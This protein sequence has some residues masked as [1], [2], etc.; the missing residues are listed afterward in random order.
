M[1]ETLSKSYF[2][3]HEHQCDASDYFTSG[4]NCIN[5]DDDNEDEKLNILISYEDLSVY[6]EEREITLN[7]KKQNSALKNVY[8]QL[9]DIL[10]KKLFILAAVD[11][12]SAKISGCYTIE[13]KNK[14]EFFEGVRL[15]TQRYLD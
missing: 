14:D 2:S 12:I 6:A 13:E 9:L 10:R 11:C 15:L 3:Q 5:D 8:F 4:L 7:N 1:Y